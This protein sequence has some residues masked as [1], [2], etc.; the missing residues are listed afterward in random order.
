VTNGPSACKSATLNSLGP[1]RKILGPRLGRVG[2]RGLVGAY[3]TGGGGGNRRGR[4]SG[5]EARA[6]AVAAV[7]MY[8]IVSSDGTKAATPL[9]PL[10]L[11]P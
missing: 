3:M 8:V 2:L 7:V 6:V 5:D 4:K 1:E 9:F 11:L 10:V